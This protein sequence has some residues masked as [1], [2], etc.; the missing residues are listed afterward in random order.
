[1]TVRAA[2]AF[3]SYAQNLEDYHLA[4]LFAGQRDGFYIDVGGGHVVAD[5]VSFGFYEKGWHGIV[6]EPQPM[7][8]AAYR[9]V[10]PRDIVVEAL[11]GRTA[12]EADF[13]EADRFHGL[14]T[15]SSAHAD[16]A[17]AAG[18]TTRLRRLPTVTLAELCAAHAPGQI[19]FLKVDVEGA[20]TE[21]LAGNDWARFRP[22]VILLE[23]VTPW[24][25]ADA[26]ASFAPILAEAGYREV[27]FD[28]LNRFYMP[29]DG[30]DLAERLPRVPTAWDAVLHLGEYGPAHRDVSHPDHALAQRIDPGCFARLNAMEA[31]D[32]AAILP[33][34]AEPGHEATR[35]ALARIA[36]YFDGGFV[37][38]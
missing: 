4:L 24:T 7:L 14:S 33:A 37:I 9:Q 19:D 18:I 32:L 11:C 2:P 35:A 15:T 13:F 12:G 23:A 5:N 8:A 22:R 1:M 26:S 27:Y 25:M 34:D 30:L 38:D 21:V 17:A 29:E 6:V 28:N 20:E 31:A 36:C 16:A 10:R 3:L